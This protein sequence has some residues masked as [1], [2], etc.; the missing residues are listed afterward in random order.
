MTQFTYLAIK[1]A[2][3]DQF[4]QVAEKLRGMGYEAD[5]NRRFATWEHKLVDDDF[6]VITYSDGVF[7]IHNHEGSASIRYTYEEF[8]KL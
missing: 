4:N 7:Q 5:G 8:M 6:Y 2:D 3:E 1:V